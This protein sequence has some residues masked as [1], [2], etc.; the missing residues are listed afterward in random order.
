[1]L[2]ISRHAHATDPQTGVEVTDVQHHLIRRG[3]TVGP[4]GPDGRFGADS[5]RATLRFQ[6]HRG[7]SVD[8]VVGQETWGLLS[9]PFPKPVTGG[10]LTQAQRFART[11]AR[12]VTGA[13]GHP[14][15]RY[16]FG[17]EVT[18]LATP[19]PTAFDCSEL[20]QW[21]VYQVT[22]D[23]WVDGSWNQYGHGRHISV[24]TAR[25]TEGALV[26]LGSTP[27]S[28]YHVGAVV[29]R[30]GKP[31]VAQARSAYLTPNCGVWPF[32][33]QPWSYAAKVPVLN[34]R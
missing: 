22:G 4:Y 24:A 1:M 25:R 26:F 12:R 27:G 21:G 8:G 34:Y 19:H 15:P 28:I 13:D 14:A 11:C 32:D 23:D 3:F 7:I 31:Y 16:I 18:N 30:S 20:M 2:P 29:I 10:R 9:H 17:Y 6:A 5:E 33:D